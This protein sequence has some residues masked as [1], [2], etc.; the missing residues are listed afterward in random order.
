M[1]TSV[2]IYIENSRISHEGIV[3]PIYSIIFL[4]CLLLRVFTQAK[5]QSTQLG[6]GGRRL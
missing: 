1:I 6:D 3:Q 2:N 5:K 4:Q